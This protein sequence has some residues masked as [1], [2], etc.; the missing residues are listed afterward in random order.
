MWVSVLKCLPLPGWVV[1]FYYNVFVSIFILK[2]LTLLSHRN[3]KICS[4]TLHNWKTYKKKFSLLFY[5]KKVRRVVLFYIFFKF[6]FYSWKREEIKNATSDGSFTLILVSVLLLRSLFESVQLSIVDSWKWN[7][8][9]PLL[10]FWWQKN[11][12]NSCFDSKNWVSLSF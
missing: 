8:E 1:V 6:N 9:R 4:R 10:V 12:D 2:C 5:K 11:F 3:S 7:F